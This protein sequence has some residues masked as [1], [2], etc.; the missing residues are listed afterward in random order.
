MGTPH[1]K[2]EKED[3]RAYM[4]RISQ[5]EESQAMLEDRRCEYAKHILSDF[6]LHLDLYMKLTHAQMGETRRRAIHF[7]RYTI[8][9][10][11]TRSFFFS[12]NLAYL[13]D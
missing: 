4:G 12:P 11:K 10:R 6:A 7:A 5:S 3:S 1:Y 9:V 13:E 8:W 2:I